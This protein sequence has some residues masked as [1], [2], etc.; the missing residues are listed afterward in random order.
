MEICC[1][2]CGKPL[3]NPASIARGMG[4]KCAGVTSAGNGF[5]SSQRASSGSAYAP[6][7]T[8]HANTNLFSVIEAR[9]DIVSEILKEFPFDL[10]NLVLS[11]PAA[12]SIA[13]QIKLY[14]HRKHE[15]NNVHPATLLKQIRRM[16]IEFRLSFWPG[17]SKNREPIPCIPCGDNDW[18]I[19]ESGRVLSKEELLS[20]L[21]RYGIISQKPV[22]TQ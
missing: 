16:C 2:K 19:G 14:S 22:E 21:R 10:V 20:Y 7:G 18:K 4:Q 13:S 5:R 12:G 9:D 11:A 3:R 6:V 8:H 15:R 1:V 17:L